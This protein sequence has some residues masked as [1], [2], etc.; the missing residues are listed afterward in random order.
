MAR[1]VLGIAG[2]AVGF[3]IAG[4][5]GARIGFVIGSVIGAI[6]DPPE[7]DGPKLGDAQVQTSRDGIPIP[8]I[9]GIQHCT[10][11]IVQMT[12]I[13]ETTVK[14]GDKKTGK[15]KSQVRKRSF[16]IGVAR[17]V[18]GPINGL[19]RAWENNKLVYDVRIG[20]SFPAEDNAAFLEA[21][22]LYL[23]TETQL[24]DPILEADTGVG[25]T[26]YYR[27]LPY[28]VFIN[29]DITNFGSSIPTYRFEVWASSTANGVGENSGLTYGSVGETQTSF[30]AQER[31]LSPP[32]FPEMGISISP[33]DIEGVGGV[34]G[35][36]E[37]KRFDRD[38]GAYPT[39][40]SYTD[41]YPQGFGAGEYIF[42]LHGI[43]GFDGFNGE[44]RPL[45]YTD[46][47]GAT[48]AFS[49]DTWYDLYAP[50]DKE[51]T[52]G[53]GD[54][55]ISDIY[56]STTITKWNW[57]IYDILVAID[58]GTGNPV[59]GSIRLIRWHN[60]IENYATSGAHNADNTIDAA[61]AIRIYPE[62]NILWPPCPT[63]NTSDPSGGTNAYWYDG[64][65]G[66]P[67]PP[68]IVPGDG[69]PLYF[70]AG[71]VGSWISDVAAWWMW[72]CSHLRVSW[73]SGV[74]DRYLIK[75]THVSGGPFLLQTNTPVTN[76]DYNV[77]FPAERC[78][79]TSTINER[80]V[81]DVYIAENAYGKWNGGP[82]TPPGT[83]TFYPVPKSIMKRRIRMG[84]TDAPDDPVIDVLNCDQSNLTLPTSQNNWDGTPARFPL[85]GEIVRQVCAKVG[86]TLVDTQVIDDVL[87]RGFMVAGVYNA[88]DT[89]RALERSYF[90]DLPEIDGELVAVLRGEGVAA[91]IMRSDM[92][93]GSEVTFETARE[94]GVEFP[95]ALH[96]SYAS[97]ETDYV[98]TKETSIRRSL[99]VRARSEIGVE[100]PINFTDEEAVKVADKMHRTANDEMQGTV[101]CATWEE[102]AYLV[103]SDPIMVE[104]SP[105]ILKRLRIQKIKMVDSTLQFECVMDRSASY[106]SGATAA[107]VLPPYEPPGNLPGD[108]TF[109]V[110]DLPALA[111]THDTLHVYIAAY[112]E[113]NKPWRGAIVEQLI[114]TT[115][116]YRDQV[117]YPSSMGQVEVAFASHAA[118]L[119]V[120]NTLT[121]SLSD[122]DI[123]SITQA[124]FDIGGNLALV[125]DELIHFRD[126]TQVG[127][128]YELDYI[129]R[130]ALKTTAGAHA[131]G[132]R[133]VMLEG[134]SAIDIAASFIGQSVTLR[135]YSIGVLPIAADEITFTFVGYSQIEWAPLGA[136]KEL[137]STDWD[138]KWGPQNRLGAPNIA[139][140]S[141]HFLGYAIE[142]EDSGTTKWIY[143]TDEFLFY[144][145]AMQTAD[146]GGTVASWDSVTIYARNSY[147]GLGN[148]ATP[149]D[150]SAG[151]D[152]LG[153]EDDTGYLMFEDDS[154]V[155]ELE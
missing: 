1:E 107:P 146:F 54:W 89:L 67:V 5:T 147:T 13:V 58:D 57:S 47:V 45:V 12:P 26:P 65:G 81:V 116:V 44:A 30:Y 127:D 15:T 64:R 85:L 153:F 17:G 38:T 99:D 118:G 134:V 78:N 68:A 77:W 138:F 93:V 119:D 96:L 35:Q 25:L 55:W 154:G 71:M 145:A 82:D 39:E 106:L 131:I 50:A 98:P 129:N 139:V 34:L 92:V 80:C 27:G 6:I 133:F 94:Q 23:G 95:Y 120:T 136:T 84:Y 9:W 52:D 103:P 112:G 19:L 108:S 16:A 43:N 51:F 56:G 140:A 141:S 73:S 104:V 110:M 28:I 155:L 22:T 150:I 74:A 59:R 31:A 79:L 42:R 3:I 124:E 90:F 24:A 29:K 91:T 128:N 21:T 88:A 135:I 60:T 40:Y 20:S 115:W 66:A 33:V 53:V 8:I 100:V 142:L 61:P 32:I 151:V 2:A 122:T 11:N 63:V 137:I 144:T 87:V 72:L 123:A 149:V 70:Q 41:T 148:P 36:I 46:D 121:V 18:H 117:T 76:R 111:Q 105:G 48:A 101:K 125:G 132:D 49:E 37:F 4:P 62:T 143:T 10:G 130:G 86:V 126:V 152:Y 113:A 114:D 7:F 83:G 109:E 102:Y 14:T 69:F 97:M 75:F